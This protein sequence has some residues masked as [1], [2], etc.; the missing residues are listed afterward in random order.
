MVVELEIVKV[1]VE[2]EEN[3]RTVEV[4]VV[5]AMVVVI[6]ESSISTDLIGVVDGLQADIYLFLG[7]FGPAPL[8]IKECFMEE[9]PGFLWP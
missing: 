7:Y 9:Q 3:M 4:I 6:Q 8:V 2:E 1:V 5:V